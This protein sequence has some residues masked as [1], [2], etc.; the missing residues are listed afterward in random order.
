M[1]K[2]TFCFLFFVIWNFGFS[3]SSL[4]KNTSDSLWA[5]WMNETEP[6]STRVEAIRLFTRDGYLFSQPDSAFFFAQLQYDFAEKN[7]LAEF[8]AYA[9]NMQGISLSIRGENDR[10]LI[11][12]FKSLSIQEEIGNRRGM[13]IVLSSI[14][15]AYNE[16]GN[17]GLAKEYHQKSLK[18]QEET[19]NKKGT[20]VSFNNL[21]NTCFYEGNFTQALEY[22]QRALIMYE[23]TGNKKG[24]AEAL[25]NIGIMYH[26]FWQTDEA[27]EYYHK[28]LAMK[29]E[30]SDKR[31]ASKSLNNLGNLYLYLKDYDK[32]EDF[33]QESL[34]L[35]IE[36][37]DIKGEAMVLNNI[38]AIYLTSKDNDKAL[39]Y[40]YKALAIQLEIQDKNGEA[41]TLNNI[42][43]CYLNKKD[44]KMAVEF[45]LK[46]YEISVA[47]GSLI[48]IRATCNNLYK[49][50]VAFKKITP[51][52][53]Y[54]SILRQT[55]LKSIN[56]NFF[57][58]TESEKES[59]F[60]N[61]EPDFGNYHD[62]TVFYH[63]SF[64]GLPDTAYN[65]ALLNK[66]LTLKS[67]TAMRSAI[68][69][70]AD[71]L[72]ISEYE[73]WIDL[74]RKISDS[75]T[76]GD[77]TKA[78]EEEAG[79]MEKNLVKKSNIFNDY[80][81]VK[82]LDWKQVRDNLKTDECAIEFVNFK[83]E[84]AENNPVIYAALLVKHRS[85]HP[86]VIRLCNE[87][88]LVE[89]LGTFQGN[90]LNFVNTV[91][92]T[93]A[94]VQLSLYQKIWQPLEKYLDDVKTI[95]YSPSGL[96]H[97]ISFA[98][99]CKEQ[100]VFLSDLYNFR[101][102]SSTG[103]VALPDDIVFNGSESFFLMGGVNY[104]TQ[105]SSKEIWSYLP[106]SLKET[107]VINSY[108]Q[109]KKY[110][111]N[112]FRSENATEENFKEKISGS[113]IVHIATHGFFFPDPEKVRKEMMSDTESNQELNFRGNA[114]NLAPTGTVE[115]LKGT[116]NYANWNFVNNKNPLMRS[117]I[118][119]ARAN[120]IWERD[121]L[122]EG[123]DGILTAQEV[124]NLDLSKTKLVVL[125]AC[126]TGLGDIHGSE[127]VFGLQR[128]FKMAGVK[129][130]IMSLWQVP[131]KETSEFMQLFYK[132]LI[133]EKD[134]PVA[135]QKTQ[136][137][138]RQKYDPYFWGAFVL[139][140]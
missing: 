3:Q 63:D 4:P 56:S 135:F 43:T 96:L 64:P 73:M 101:Q 41:Q 108:L 84:I 62:F 129:Y 79:T 24:T 90:N 132:N 32:A 99:I 77:D 27:L 95:Y 11:Y 110:A 125:S 126:E 65:I 133:K 70:S 72:L 55:L 88:E 10:A 15:T 17:Y 8:M 116:T 130:L 28:S 98:A 42:S 20:G 7:Q 107:D 48:Q 109:K 31:G 81:N 128:A 60:A 58:L 53:F 139:I 82:N 33:L 138:M 69:N 117:G 52:M 136:K 140:E 94:E 47:I 2:I 54:L 14:G 75:Y 36:V 18:I 6:D 16:I 57:S 13:A 106:G 74:K 46:S 40:F 22:Y 67:S 83:S 61:M 49:S 12:F 113:G 29:Q 114:L 124:S 111:V 30:L 100:N 35:K 112:Y 131:D 91:Y 34:R 76:N 89:I 102:M 104:N 115:G 59:Y 97:K 105:K 1:K 9:L 50:F 122:A 44:Y 119:L 127:G 66:G 26:E 103:K 68:L 25:N 51:G 92:G 137:V 21:G 78:I 120:A 39:E 23:E 87:S 118:V 5:I 37:K 121:A 71:S 123:E 85:E 134:V 38:A 93:R 19:G 45:G 80:N 86:E